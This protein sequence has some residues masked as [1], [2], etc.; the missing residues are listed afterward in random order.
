[1]QIDRLFQIVQ[2]LLNHDITT[3]KALA[4][5]FQVSQRTIYRDLDTLSVS[6]VP[7]LTTKGKG[8]GISLLKDYTMD[9]SLLTEEERNHL[10]MG[11][12][13]LKATQADDVDQVLLKLKDLFHDQKKS[14]IR[15][16]FSHWGND[17]EERKKF[18]EIKDAIARHRMLTFHYTDAS[19]RLSER[20]VA[21][22]QLL[23]KE[24]AWYL[25]AYCMLRKDYRFFKLYRITN[26]QSSLR[27]FDPNDYPLEQ[28]LLYESSPLDPKNTD[29]CH[30]WASKM[31]SERI[32]NEFSE[33]QILHLGTGDFILKYYGRHDDWL[34]SYILGFGEHMKVIGPDP[35]KDMVQNT[36]K[37]MYINYYNMTQ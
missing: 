35:L 2:I 25:I 11:L 3:A 24:K 13:T 12:E 36:I 8:G 15:V 19:N 22:I 27:T 1:M 17:P 9:R 33:D 23:F 26:L 32:Y 7:V 14:W 21:P 30:L 6:G 31:V 28:D 5:R 37:K 20:E 34:V 29:I 16:D 18:G 4:Q 10:I